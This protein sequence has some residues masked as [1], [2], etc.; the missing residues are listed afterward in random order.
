MPTRER[1]S[2]RPAAIA[3]RPFYLSNTRLC[4]IA[5]MQGWLV[6]VQHDLVKRLLWP[7]RD[8]RD[9]GGS[10]GPGELVPRLIDDEGRP[11]TAAALWEELRADAEAPAPVL[12]AFGAAVASAVAAAERGDIAGVLALDDAFRALGAAVRKEGR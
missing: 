5:G 3:S 2:T 10:P 11:T 8:R 9:M 4:R 1:P 6:R 7:A 12:D